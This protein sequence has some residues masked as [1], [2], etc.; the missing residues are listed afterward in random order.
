MYSN[1]SGVPAVW[2]QRQGKAGNGNLGNNPPSISYLE[3]FG[4]YTVA[5]DCGDDL[6]FA[7]LCYFS[8]R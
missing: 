2:N 4:M 8:F 1:V 7:Y 5:G 3:E 6:H